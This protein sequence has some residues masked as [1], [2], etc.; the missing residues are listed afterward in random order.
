MVGHAPGECKD[1]TEFARQCVHQDEAQALLDELEHDGG[2]HAWRVQLS[3]GMFAQLCRIFVDTESGPIF[4]TSAR[5][6]PTFCV[7]DPADEKTHIPS[8][9]VHASVTFEAAVN[10][11]AYNHQ[12]SANVGAPSRLDVSRGAS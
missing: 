12:F 3:F 4:K 2:V 5:T 8:V 7:V 9:K 1:P 11:F 6:Q 10:H